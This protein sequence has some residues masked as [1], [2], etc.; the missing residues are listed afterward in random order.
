MRKAKLLF[1]RFLVV[2]MILSLMLDIPVNAQELGMI[3]AQSNVSDSLEVNDGLNGDNS[4]VDDL[5]KDDPDKENSNNGDSGKDDSNEDD[6]NKDGSNEDDPNKDDS[7]EDD[8]NKDGSNEDDPNKDGFNEDDPGKDDSDKEDIGE[9]G[10][11]QDDSILNETDDSEFPD[12]EASDLDDADD[13]EKNKTPAFIPADWEKCQFFIFPQN[14][15]DIIYTVPDNVAVMAIEHV[16][17]T[18][19]Y[20]VNTSAVDEVIFEA[21]VHYG[22]SLQIPENLEEYINEEQERELINDRWI[23]RYNLNVAQLS[24]TYEKPFSIRFK[25]FRD[26][27]SISVDGDAKVEGVDE[28]GFAELGSVVSIEVLNPGETL[29]MISEDE[30]GNTIYTAME[31]DYNNCYEFTVEKELAFV[32][33]NPDEVNFAIVYADSRKAKFTGVAGLKLKTLASS[34]QGYN[35][36]V[37]NFTA[38]PNGSDG[39]ETEDVYYEIKVTAVPKNGENIPAGSSET[40]KYYYVKKT[41]NVNVQNKSVMVNDGDLSAPTACTYEFS[42]RLLHL[43]KQISVPNDNTPLTTPLEAVL[44][45]NTITKTFATKNL[46]YE[47]KLG[48]TK[49]NTKIYTG[50]SDLLAG[51]VKYSKKASYL[52]DLT[53]VAYNQGGA[54]DDNITCTF[55]NDNDELYVSADEETLP[56]K[57]TIVIYAGIG[58]D[59]TKDNPQGGTMY[60]ANTSF[61]LTVEA[62]INY[63]NTNAIVKQVSVENKNVTF[64]AA[65]VGYGGYWYDKAKSQKFTYEIKSAVKGY[66]GGYNVIEPT[67]KVQKSISVNKSGKVTIKKDYTV[68]PDVGEDY[69]AIIIKAADFENNKATETVYIRILNTVLVPT[70]IHLYNRYGKDLGTRFTADMANYYRGSYN[71]FVSAKVVVLDQ[72]GNNMNQYVTITPNYSVSGNKNGVDHAVNSD[73]ATLYIYKMGTITI[74]AVSTD[75]GKKSKSVNFKVTAPEI[76]Q[77]HYVQQ[78]RYSVHSITYN[79]SRVYDY[80]TQTGLVTYSAPKGSVIKVY[81]GIDIDYDNHTKHT[82]DDQECIGAFN[83]SWFNWKHE[84]KGGKLKISGNLCEITPTE[85]TATLYVWPKSNPRQRTQIRF[86]NTS[87][88]DYETAPKVTLASGKIYSNKYSKNSDLGEWYDE[89]MDEWVSG[90]TP[91]QLNYRY[92]SGFYDSIQITSLSKNAPYL[93]VSDFNGDNRTFKLKTDEENIKPGS[94]KYRVAFYNYKKGITGETVSSM[95]A[96]TATITVKVNKAPKIKISSSY[97]LN[98]GQGNSSIALK[99]TPGDFIPD[100]DTKLLN[101]NMG[102]KTNDFSDYFEVTTSTDSMGVSRASV[103]F[104]DTLTPEQKAALKG[105]TLTGYVKYNY[106]YGYNYIENATSKITIKIK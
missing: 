43:D 11:D 57:Y 48:F 17:P 4:N 64:S 55:K 49:K 18:T 22:Y 94:Y 75:G 69:I 58:E 35:E 100:F 81:N 56:G 77:T 89:W 105:K 27:V 101:A 13:K 10:S 20:A 32:V 106:Y 72:F 37:L 54:V 47:D 39:T 45:G 23:Y 33:V 87:W 95:S 12:N 30:K 29:A 74:K 78:C 8:P 6:P 15:D 91:Q 70:E 71:F 67:E 28:N 40:P 25:S 62:G 88:K 68:D 85:K 31:L 19:L 1:S 44:S 96:K 2:V 98:T 79:G 7:N 97:T 3:N 61:T 104:K 26:E 51:T 53:A 102:G 52:H 34:A 84:I 83:R 63:I 36:I 41:E 16:A 80:K 60:Q 59:L 86:T 38:V 82:G 103:K 92:D 99:C 24:S 73:D 93:W 14:K 46:Y 5:D 21:S 65:P 66:Y 50:Q 9:D 42:V 76:K 90:V